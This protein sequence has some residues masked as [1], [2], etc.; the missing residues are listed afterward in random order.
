MA[1]P[2]KLSELIERFDREVM[3]GK[4]AYKEAN[5]RNQFIDPFFESL[6]WDLRN[7]QGR[8]EVILEDRVDTDQ[9]LKAADYAF[10]VDNRLK[11]FVE[12]KKP[13]VNLKTDIDSAYQVRRYGWSASLPVSILTDFEEFV[14]YDCRIEP[15][16]TDTPRANQLEYFKYDQYA[17]KWDWIAD[18]FSRQAVLDGALDSYAATIK[19]PRGLTTVD[20][21]FLREIETWRELLARNLA[22][23][24]PQLSQ[25]ELNFAVQM[26]IDRI[27]FLRICEDREIEPYG[28]LQHLEQTQHVYEQLIGY[29]RQADEK[30]NSGLFHFTAEKGHAEG[31]DSLTLGLTVGDDAL[32]RIIRTLY[33]PSP[34]AFRYIPVEILGQVYEQ[35][36]GKVIRLDESHNAQVEAKPE[37]RKAGGVYY[38]PT[39]IVEYIVRNTVGKLLEDKTVDQADRLRVLDPACGSGSF[40]LGAYQHLLDWYLEQYRHDPKKYRKRLDQDARGEWRLTI[41]E[42]KRILLN[43][44]FGVDIDRQ[45]VEVTKLSLLLRVLE[46]EAGLTSQLAMFQERVLPD[47]SNNIKCGN[48]LIGSDFYAQTTM[49]FQ[50]EEEQYRINAFDWQAEFKT[51]MAAGGFDAVIG[52]P[53]YGAELDDIS[54]KFLAQKFNLNSTDTAALMMAQA[55]KLV[56]SGGWNGFIVPKPFIYSSN[57]KK[58]REI[59]LQELT[60]LIDVG[61]VWKE[62]KLEQVIYFFNKEISS[63]HYR[64]LQRVNQELVYL[65]DISKTDCRKFEFYLNGISSLDLIIGNKLQQTNLFLGDITTNIRGGMFQN[66]VHENASGKRVLGGK[67][68]QR[69]SI[70]G[71]KGYINP[72]TVLPANAFVKPDSILVQNI[73][74]HIANPVDH[75]KIIGT[76]IKSEVTGTISILDTVNQLANQ[77]PFSVNYI[78]GLLFSKLLNW[79]IYRFI[80]AKAIRTMHFDGPVSDRVPIRA[81]NFDDPTDKGRHDRMVELVERMLDLH[82]RQAGAR[83]AT[84]KTV[85]GRQIEATDREIDRLVYELYGLT[86]EEIQLV[87]GAAGP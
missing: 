53:P 47:L 74:A 39:Y 52:N 8:A 6:G 65:T 14:V 60:E 85:L 61:K 64:S 1:L 40:L 21:A 4:A 62:V 29:F 30:Y 59:F 26:T 43:N 78:A 33:Y 48:S 72:D 23:L 11:F 51:I 75:I 81:I 25:R 13:S 77:S 66:L 86:E 5:I 50:D 84:D 7:V 46:G 68:I 31:P 9:G 28:R 55:I 32:H 57:W 18:R 3:P 76:V 41:A 80:F 67:Q 34:Y 36:L 37:V 69:Y 12:A 24:N 54:R 73:I 63:K 71:E 2:D 17:A 45:A 49:N 16:P 20:A 35:F 44:I 83:L 87:E 70:I 38:T 10:R 15:N 58:V 19:E 42:R 22:L 56:K 27:I 82:K 79:Y